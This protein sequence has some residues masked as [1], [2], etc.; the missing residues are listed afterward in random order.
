[1]FKKISHEANECESPKGVR[2]VS[3]PCTPKA[4]DPTD[5]AEGKHPPRLRLPR[6]ALD[7]NSTSTDLKSGII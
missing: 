2:E 7:L 1:M 5:G 4:W 6:C 3:R